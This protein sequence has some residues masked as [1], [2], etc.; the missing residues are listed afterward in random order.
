MSKQIRPDG[1]D[2]GS[3]AGGTDDSYTAST[4]GQQ[5]RWGHLFRYSL[6]VLGGPNHSI[7]FFFKY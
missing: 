4:D 3:A 5:R 7:Q 2:K 1:E 6:R